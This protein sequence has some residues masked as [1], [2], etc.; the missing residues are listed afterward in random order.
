ME[1]AEPDHF[2]Q[3]LRHLGEEKGGSLVVG[4]VSVFG[5]SGVLTTMKDV[6]DFQIIRRN[7]GKEL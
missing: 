7:G 1:K 5:H 3:V 6:L 4:W 2:W